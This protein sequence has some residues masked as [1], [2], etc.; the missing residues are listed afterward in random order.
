[1]LDSAAH[2]EHRLPN[3]GMT[4]AMSAYGT[5]QLDGGLTHLKY[6]AHIDGLRAIAVLSVVGFHAFPDWIFSGFVG[7]DVFFVISGFLISAIILTNLKSNHFS[8]AGFYARRIKRIFPALFAVIATCFALGWY[9][10][11]PDEFSQLLKHMAAGAGFVSNFV[12]WSEA[13]YFDTSAHTKPLLHLW[14]L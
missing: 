14:S 4:T 11:L 6:H 9:V 2:T 7:V 8:Y 10:L 12:L 5:A 3:R 13:G 1:M